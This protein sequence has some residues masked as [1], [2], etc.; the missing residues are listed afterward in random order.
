MNY[1]KA[2]SLCLPLVL[3]IAGLYLFPLKI[4]E[5]DFAKIPGDYGDA[6]FNNYIF[7]HGYKFLS[8][9]LPA[10]WDA[11]FMYPYANAIAF[12]DNLLG[13]LPIYS[14]YRILG[15]DRETAFQFWI[16]TMFALNFVCCYAALIKWSGNNILSATGAYIFGFSIFILGHIYNVQTLPRFIAPFVFYWCWKYFSEK[17]Y[18][19]FLLTLFGIV[20]QFYCG[21]YL[22]FLLTYTILFLFLAYIVIYR[23]MGLFKQFKKPKI[24]LTHLLGFFLMAA[25]LAPMMLHYIDIAH[26]L[27]MH[28]YKDVES[29]IPTLRSYF[30]TS[31]APIM[32]HF[33]SQHAIPLLESWWCH[34]LFMGAVPWLGVLSLLFIF[35]SKKINSGRKKFIAFLSLSLLFSFIFCLNINGFSLY[36]LIFE[37]PGFSSMRSMNRII[38]TEAVLFILVFVFSFNELSKISKAVKWLVF[39]FPAL[40]VADNLI[41]PKGVNAYSKKESQEVIS[42][43][44]K[45]IENTWDKKRAIAYLSNDIK[46]RETEFQLN[47]MLASQELNIACV[48]AYSGGFPNPYNNFFNR[49]TEE[50][51]LEWLEF[52]QMERSTIQT[53]R[54][55]AQSQDLEKVHLLAFN[56]KYVSADKNAKQLIANRDNAYAWE[57]FTFV[58]CKNKQWAIRSFENL[59][60]CPEVDKNSEITATRSS[61][62]DWETFKMIDFGKNRIALQAVN[63]KYLSVDDKS[64]LLYAKSD[65]IGVQ[66]K[67]LLVY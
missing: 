55:V 60:V 44:R 46:E 49:P 32:W 20:Y 42:S 19:Y 52:N 17:Q 6:R 12:S 54:E 14:A 34:F 63:G 4:F 3:L 13:T 9:T 40:V 7:E 26:K 8:G 22:G 23:D 56:S 50:S 51:L 62:G 29:T 65:S 1:K 38:N 36:R 58:N 39:C 59:F 10:Y 61:V 16:L 21:V 5:S 66:E 47:V 57:T 24:I 67:F 18:K 53:I 43:V 11:P 48:N 27:G 41:D 37:L 64:L 33:L 35:L 31:E 25:L 45:N 15:N 30:F 2:V 28:S